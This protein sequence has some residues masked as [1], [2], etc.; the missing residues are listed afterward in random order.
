MLYKECLLIYLRGVFR[1]SK[2]NVKSLLIL[3]NYVNVMY[4]K[5]KV[6]HYPHQCQGNKNT[7]HNPQ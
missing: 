5:R 2:L 6:L 1:S 4:V 7:Q 3:R